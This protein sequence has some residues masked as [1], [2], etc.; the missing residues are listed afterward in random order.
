[1]SETTDRILKTTAFRRIDVEALLDRN[2]P[3]WVRFD[4]E[5]GY[6]P[7]NVI[8]RDGIG[9][10]FSTYRHEPEG[11]RK[12][13]NYAD[14]PCRINTYGDSFTQCQQVSDGETWQECLAAHLGEPVRNFGSGG[15]SVNAAV[16]RLLRMEGTAVGADH[17]ILNVFD[18]DHIRNLDAARWIRT[19]WN[20]RDKPA[21]IA[22]PLHGLPWAHLRYDLEQGT[23]VERPGA[24]ESE[25]ALLALCDPEAFHACFHDDQVVR[26]FSLMLGGEEDVAEFEA[27]AEAFQVKL[28]LRDPDRRAAEAAR[29]H[30]VYGFRSTRY[31]LEKLLPWLEARGKRLLVVLSYAMCRIPEFLGGQPRFDQDF[32]DFLDARDIP[33]V[34]GLLKHAEDFRK[35]NLSL[36]DYV[37]RYYIN[38]AGSAVFGHYNPLGNLF[39]AFSIKDEVVDWLNPRPPAYEKHAVDHLMIAD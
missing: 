21:D 9:D 35:F 37:A 29:L 7:D 25:E 12:L 5:L 30:A 28:D 14:R 2:R 27:L 38:P 15:Y 8:M 10:S 11:H 36:E 23:F 3:S 4:P 19:A 34:D 32:I 18:D 20:E 22:F 31:L 33:Y 24:C 13:V 26:L 16:R 6:V 39:Y 1:M 17:I